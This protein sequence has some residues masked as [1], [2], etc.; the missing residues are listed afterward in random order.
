MPSAPLVAVVG[1]GLAGAACARALAAGGAQVEVHDRGRAPGGRLASPRI[2]GRPV[3]LGGSYLTVRDAGFRRVVDDWLAR[4][5]ARPWTDA[6][7]VATPDGLGEVKRGPVRYGTPLGLR[8]LV[9]DLLEGLD[10][11]T[12][13]T[14]T[15]VGPGPVVD[16]RAYDAVVLA[17]P[18]PQALRLLDASLASER[19]ALEGRVWEPVLAL[20]AAWDERTWDETLDGC[21]VHGSDVLAWIADDGRRRGDDAAVL[22]AHST[23]PLAAARLEDPDSAG[24]L[25]IDRVRQVLAIASPPRWARVQRWTYARPA[26]PREADHHLGPARVGVCGDGWGSPRAETAW[27]SGTALA[28]ALLEAL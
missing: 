20:A 6:F 5:L 7:H 27:R 17:M 9:A 8:S 14:V 22:V 15:A 4:G 16:G 23:S 12:G 3:D 13:S 11:R 2:D 10:V 25:L 18:D 21:F 24:G 28:R 26:E 19:A 1:A